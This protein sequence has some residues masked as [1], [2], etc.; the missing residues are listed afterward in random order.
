MSAVCSSSSRHPL[1]PPRARS[2]QLSIP[3]FR[4]P[5]KSRPRR[6]AADTTH[7]ITRSTPPS[8]QPHPTYHHGSQDRREG[9]RKLLL[10]WWLVADVMRQRLQIASS[11]SR[12]C[13]HAHS[14]RHQTHRQQLLGVARRRARAAL[15]KHARAISSERG[16]EMDSFF[17]P[18]P[19]RCSWVA[20]EEAVFNGAAREQPHPHTHA[21]PPPLPAIF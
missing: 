14:A 12:C 21:A 1:S 10:L 2:S 11:S 8:P 9:V 7:S 20:A 13:T 3:K 18:V 5:Y 17:L 4:R 15:P 16:S 6:T 19:S